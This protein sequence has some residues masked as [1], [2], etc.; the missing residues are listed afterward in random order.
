MT[1]KPTCRPAIGQSRGL[2]RASACFF[3]LLANNINNK[4]TALTLESVSNLRPVAT[5]SSSSSSSSSSSGQPAPQQLYRSATLDHLSP[6]DATILLNEKPII[7]DLRNSDEIN[8]GAQQRT[9][10]ATLFYSSLEDDQLVRVP[11]LSDVDSFWDAAVDRMPRAA[12]LK[13]T[14]QTTFRAGA[15]DR[16]AARQLERGG[17]P[18]L[19]GVMLETCGGPL[20]EALQVCAERVNDD[21]EEHYLVLFHC[22]KGKDRTGILAMLLQHCMGET[23]EDLIRSYGRSGDLLGESPSS[24]TSSSSATNEQ[25]G[26][27]D[28]SH[29]RGSPEAAMEE[30]LAWMDQTYGSVDGYLDR[31]S[32]SNDQRRLLRKH[33]NDH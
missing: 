29:F 1:A 9:E 2:L 6:Q 22:Q 23:K 13:A 10:G 27:V 24:T 12:R 15:L 14:L 30:T 21:D 4:I 8:R 16:A 28:W 33:A 5:T 11:I 17:L 7:L 32:F 20:Q 31:I 25:T 3:A 19:Y 26:L 18:A